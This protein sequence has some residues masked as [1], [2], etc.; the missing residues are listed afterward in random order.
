VCE[1]ENSIKPHCAKHQEVNASMAQHTSR[2][3]AENG[4]DVKFPRI[5]LLGVTIHRV[6]MDEVLSAV[7]HYVAD[8][9]SHILVTADSYGLVLAQSDADF[10]E[11]INRADLVTPDSSGILMGARWLGTALKDR[12]SGID[13]A[14]RVCEMAAEEGFSIFLLGAAPGVAEL[15]AENLKRRYPGL[16]IA[17][18]HHGYFSDDK[19]PA[20][21]DQ[22]RKSGAQV[23]FVALGIPKQEKWI[24]DNLEDLRVGLAMGI[25]GSLDVISG[26]I[27]RAPVWMQRHGLE[28]VYRLSKD[29]RKISKVSSL[30]IY[31]WL[32]L[33]E[34]LRCRKG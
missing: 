1:W 15:A 30:P 2:H 11:I 14:V 23:L 22:I 6:D 9:A 26:R 7:R 24:S 31:L 34:K 3:S 32:L 21:V 19:T 27:K 8:G 12:V 25:G 17:G 33:K 13:I 5:E 20:I 16:T 18:T 4:N 10:R 28:W 29:P